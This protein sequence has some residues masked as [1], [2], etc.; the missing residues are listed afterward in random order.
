MAAND[1]GGALADFARRPPREKAMIFGVIALLMGLLYWQFLL[2]PLQKK[3]K[4]EQVQNQTLIDEGDTLSAQLEQFKDLGT[5]QIALNRKIEED[6]KALPTE[7]ELP[8]FF[9]T[10]NR[11]VGDAGVEVRK[12]EYEH[13]TKVDDFYRVPIEIELTGTWN[14]MK[15]FF[16][17]LVP[18]DETG[19]AGD[20]PKEEE[21]IITIEDLSIG[22]PVVKN[23]EILLTARFTASTF[24]QDEKKPD[25]PKPGTP[26]ATPAPA[27]ATPPAGSAA[28]AGSGSSAPAGSAAPAGS[29][30]APAG[31]GSG[32]G[33]GSGSA[34]PGGLPGEV[35][36][37]VQG[38]V[39]D[40]A[41]RDRD[42][43]G[44]LKGGL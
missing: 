27:S 44:K 15:R 33:K 37:E 4:R 34:A 28:P 11:K 30:A 21:R 22:E 39:D 6:R 31:S 32:S 12:W 20:L 25:P 29:G 10:L 41:K 19:A 36:H 7:A 9:E 42:A 2:R 18:H 24:R 3:F 8:A 26:A 13:E 23:G 35:K 1:A 14:Q 17:S 16:V 40:A 5:K 43:A 38:S